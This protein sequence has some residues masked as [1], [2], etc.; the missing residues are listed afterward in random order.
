MKIRVTDK[1]ENKA[2]EMVVVR[3]YKKC[4]ACK[5]TNCEHYKGNYRVYKN[6]IGMNNDDYKVEVIEG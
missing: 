5:V 4:Y 3:E 6:W 2:T 1:K